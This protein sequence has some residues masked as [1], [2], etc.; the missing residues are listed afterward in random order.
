MSQRVRL[1]VLFLVNAPITT[2]T[3]PP[4]CIWS[5]EEKRWLRDLAARHVPHGIRLKGS[6]SMLG[7]SFDAEQGCWWSVCIHGRLRYCRLLKTFVVVIG[8]SEHEAARRIL[9]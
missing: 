3:V 4:W 8:K 5:D 2:A 6:G 9:M 1:V 7:L